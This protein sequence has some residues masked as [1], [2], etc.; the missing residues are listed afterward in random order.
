MK[1]ISHSLQCNGAILSRPEQI[2]PAIRDKNPQPHNPSILNP[3]IL[4]SLDS[5]TPKL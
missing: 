4:Q 1:F 5:Q 3:S 2:G